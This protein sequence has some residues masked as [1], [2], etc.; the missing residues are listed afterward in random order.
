MAVCACIAAGQASAHHSFA[1]FDT[2]Q[3][4]SVEG[5]V[6]ELQWANPH[7]WL[8]V[9]VVDKD[10]AQ[11]EHSFE[12]FGMSV[13]KRAGWSRDTFKPGVKVTVEFSPF[14]DGRKG[15]QLLKVI[16]GDGVEF[17]LGRP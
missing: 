14:K 12:A 11:E 10:G 8:E 4:L 7:V 13:L 9:I 1:A 17:P 15:G 5:T 6:K 2:S 16:R 3:R